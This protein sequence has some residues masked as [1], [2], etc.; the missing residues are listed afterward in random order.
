MVDCSKCN[1]LSTAKTSNGLG[2]QMQQ[3]TA[4]R[5]GTQFTVDMNKGSFW[6]HSPL[7]NNHR[8][9]LQNIA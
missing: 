9:E 2:T 1:Q 6:I 4:S 7:H 5:L 8:F 3:C